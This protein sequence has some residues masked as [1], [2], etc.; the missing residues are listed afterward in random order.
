MSTFIGQL[1]GFALIVWLVVKF[2]LPPLRTMMQRQQDAV[3]V[4]LEESASAADKLANADQVHAKAIT[5]AQAEAARVTE[6]A[7]H[8]AVRIG[9]QLREQAVTDAE[10]I[11]AQGGQQ[12]QLLRQQ[13]IRGLRTD[14][15]DE[16]VQ[17][18]EALVRAHVADPAAQSATVDRFLDELGAM[19]TTDA[20]VSTFDAGASLNLRATSR[21][22]LAEVVKSVD[23][24]VEGLDYDALTKL[25][26]E[27]SGAAR[28]LHREP[29]LARA[30]T[31]PTADVAGRVGLVR[32]LLEGKVGAPALEVLSSAAA[33]RWS[34]DNDIIDAVEHAAR[35]ALVIAG[36]RNGESGALE[37]QLFRTGRILD[38]NPRLT[39]LLSDFNAPVDGRIALLD[40]V[41]D[42][43]D[44]SGTAAAL[45]RQNVELLRGQRIDETV[46]DLVELSVAR[47]GELV[48]HVTAAADLTPEQKSR[49]ADILRRIY[50]HPVSVHLEI[51]PDLLGG[52]TITVGDEVVDGTIASRLAAARNGLP[53]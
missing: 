11:K 20:A 24:T 19:S 14:L 41:L 27:L 34:A 8:D 15:G 48:A 46:E 10:R 9:E 16:S 25:A 3:R 6:E 23:Q 12:V 53:D 45:L 7:R 36:E 1:I 22:A 29:T 21:E 35:L 38:A 52:L 49:L 4:A 47:R 31:K 5:D 13:T 51:D 26:G 18:A 17:R 2:V 30:L 43:A 28:L 33:Q 37:E 39:T 32:K 42:S 50:G 40:K 44:G